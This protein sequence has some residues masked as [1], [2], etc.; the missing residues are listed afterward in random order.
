MLTYPVM[1]GWS[2][3]TIVLLAP[4]ALVAAGIAAGI[5]I[6]AVPVDP[7]PR[8]LAYAAGAL[9]ACYGLGPGSR[10]CPAAARQAL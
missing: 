5:T 2:V 7:F 3:I 9:V 10:R 4:L 1:L 6:V 8:A